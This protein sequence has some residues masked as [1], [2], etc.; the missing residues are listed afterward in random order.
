MFVILK[1]NQWGGADKNDS[2]I[3][4]CTGE[5]TSLE[6]ELREMR[7]WEKRGFLGK[8]DLGF[9][10]RGRM[11]QRPGLGAEEHGQSGCMVCSQALLV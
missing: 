4:L 8:T 9:W 2:E 10:G 6:C 11:Q 7:F 3:Q 1:T 5:K